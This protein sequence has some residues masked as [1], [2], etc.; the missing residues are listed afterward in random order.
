M[1]KKALSG[2]KVVDCTELRTGPYATKLLA[3]LGAEVI[4]IEDPFGGDEARRQGPY[5]GDNPNSEKSGLFLWLNAN[6]LGLT[7]NLRTAL[8]RKV[9]KEL[10]KQADVFIEEMP[11]A[12]KRE[13]GLDYESLSKINPQLVVTSITPFGETGP[14]KDYKA[15]EINCSAAGGLSN[16]TGYPDREPLIFPI[17]SG[18]YQC[19]V[20]VASSSL[21][22]ALVRRKIGE[23][24]HASISATEVLAD[25]HAGQYLIRYIYQGVSGNRRGHHAGYFYYPCSCLPCKD[26]HMVLIAPQLSQWIRFVELMGNPEWSENPRYRNRRA[27]FEE[28]PDEADELLK[29][30]LA[31]H[32]KAEIFDMSRENHLPFAPV[33]TI[34]E[35]VK[36]PQ[37][38]ARKFFSGLSH[39]AAG[40]LRYPGAAYKLSRTPARLRKPAP[41]LGEHN[42][43]ILC[44]RLGY[45]EDDLKRMKEYGVV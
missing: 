22:A 34:D 35:V 28:Y 40:R 38:R 7:L 18:D 17:S 39:P 36:D 12:V 25:D 43:E 45:S 13:L 9:L 42:H 24:Q 11:P 26:G 27:M 19:G 21:V 10:L 31:K 2:L 15:Y 29:V 23:G 14:Y 4:K 44:K 5:P 32:D 8:G 33:Q 3:D 41:C 37:L 6:K 16:A 30:W 20:A 1:T